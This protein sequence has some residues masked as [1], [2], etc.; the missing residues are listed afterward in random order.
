MGIVVKVSVKGSLALLL[1]IA[2]SIV[3]CVLGFVLGSLGLPK[4]CDNFCGALLATGKL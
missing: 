3:L 2:K 4:L 1:D